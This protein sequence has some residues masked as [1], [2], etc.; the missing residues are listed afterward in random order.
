MDFD[1]PYQKMCCL[2]WHVGESKPVSLIVP[3]FLYY[4]VR[5]A[6]AAKSPTA[7]HA[8]VGVH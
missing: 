1:F 4:H 5:K 6:D 3:H 7:D 8:K 2:F